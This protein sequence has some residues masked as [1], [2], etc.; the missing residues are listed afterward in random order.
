MVF[1]VSG[2]G[3]YFLQI[4]QSNRACAPAFH[5]LKV[6][7]A[8]DIPHEKQTF[9]RPDI[10]AGGNHIHSHGNARVIGV[11]KLRQNAFGVVAVISYFFAEPV[12][13]AKFFPDDLNDIV[14]VAV[15]LGEDERFGH[16]KFVFFIDAVGKHFRQMLFEGADNRADLVGIDNIVI[17]L[18]AGVADV[19]IQLL[20]ALFARELFAAIHILTFPD[21]AAFFRNFGINDINI[22]ADVDAV[23]HGLFVRVFADDVL[24]EKAK[25]PVV[26]RGG[27]AD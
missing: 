13:F 19:F 22:A 4:V 27:K 8:F 10:G 21:I 5:L 24:V 23:G 7:A 1:G 3:R 12:F 17:K 6:V 2:G 15:G 16:F 9:Q 14:G 26:G 18:F 25:R 11:A 20:P